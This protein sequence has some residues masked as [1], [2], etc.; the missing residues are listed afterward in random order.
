MKVTLNW[1]KQYV[2][3]N[4]SPEELAER[5]T[6]LGLEVEGV[7]KLGGEFAGVVVGQVLTKDKVAGSDKLSVNRVADGTGERTIICGAQNHQPGDKV[8][9]ILPN[10][11]LPLKA[12]E[13][14]PFVIKER[15]VFGVVSQGMMCSNKELGLGEDGDGIIILPP[16][17]KVGQPF[18]EHLGR[19]GSDV[20]Y[21]LEVT[22]NRPDLNS[23]I[24]IAREIAALTGNA[25][26][27]P[28]ISGQCSVVSGEVGMFVAVK[29]QEPE[30]CPRYTARVVTGVKVGPSPDW[31]RQTLEKVGIRSISNVVDVTNYVM[32]ETGQPLHAFDYHL[33]AKSGDGKPTIVVRRAT[34][35]EKFKALDNQERTLTSDM[36]LIADEQKGIALAGVMGGANTEICDATRDVLIESAYFLPTNI[37]RTSK[38]LGLR[39]ESSY[40]FERGCDVGIADYASQRAAQLILETAGGTLVPGVVDAYPKPA[41]PKVICLKHD[42]TNALLGVEIPGDKQVQMLQSLDLEFHAQIG[43]DERGA[44]ATSF[45][46]PSFRVDL[47]REV[48]LI[49]EIA[50]LHGVD[51]IPSTP[52]RGAVGTNAFDAVY[53]QLADVRRLLTGLG[54]N[55]AQGQTLISSAECGMRNTEL[56]LLANPLS[57]D[58]DLLRPSLLPGLLHSLRHNLHRKNHDVALFEI[59]RVFRSADAHIRNPTGGAAAAD[60]GVRAPVEERRVAIALT[61]QR[62]LAFW[63]GD[64][65]DAKFDAMD[66]K[67]L[68]EDLLEHFGLRGI[69]FGKR[70][71]PTAI[72]LES[73]A[74][75]LGGKVQLGELGQLLPAL[76]K[77]YDLRDAVFLAELRL[78]E[79][80]ARGNDSKSFKVLPQFPASRRDVAMLVPEATT[81]D[82][83]LQAVKQAKPANLE[84][85]E[86]FDVFRGKNVP[87]GQKSLAYAFTYRA[88]DKTLTDSDVSASHTKAVDALKQKLQATVRE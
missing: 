71:E 66:L 59:G 79:L 22:P 8:A 16:N 49:E 34:A 85:V 4:W 14:E 39:S 78:D 67:G 2:D 65:R 6:M 69:M 28:V 11:A 88:A 33:I 19:A 75:T 87:A 3:F 46:I 31:L 37:R 26:K 64:D 63:S 18:A 41:E 56:V 50:R 80:I 51:K 25:L 13:K 20:V 84:S 35:E 76:A 7:Q 61:G 73:A 5:L 32:L 44:V 1:L 54:L 47:K 62:A 74:I 36:L 24:G 29:L 17:A 83:V 72:F 9:V 15:K 68:V 55:E 38:A 82:A 10:F 81:H 58:M 57:S 23:V 48:D 77:D 21:D 52:P 53:D 43:H 70:A 40:R 30:L 45:R 27:L 60:V 12:G 86:L 42:K